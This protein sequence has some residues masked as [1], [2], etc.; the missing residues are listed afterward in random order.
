MLT[1]TKNFPLAITAGMNS[2]GKVIP[3]HERLQACWQSSPPSSAPLKH[4]KACVL[5]RCPCTKSPRWLVQEGC[6]GRGFLFLS[7]SFCGECSYNLKN[8]KWSTGSKRK[9]FDRVPRFKMCWHQWIWSACS[10][11]S[12]D[13]K[14]C[15]E[16]NFTTKTQ[17]IFSE[18]RYSIT[19]SEM[20][21]VTVPPSPAFRIC[22]NIWARSHITFFSRVFHSR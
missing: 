8:R 13:L 5:L 14:G 10:K 3:E 9:I 17:P 22:L 16:P 6:G 15:T 20:P 12:T 4:R 2:Q 18:G 11:G 21:Y 19:F 1:H 7:S